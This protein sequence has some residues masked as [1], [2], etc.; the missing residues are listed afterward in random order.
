[1]YMNEPTREGEHFSAK[2][3]QSQLAVRLHRKRK[4]KRGGFH[5]QDTVFCT[6]VNQLP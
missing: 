1:M 3:F 4:Y 2:L 6:H 5:E